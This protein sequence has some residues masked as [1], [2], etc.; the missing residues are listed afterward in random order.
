MFCILDVNHCLL[1]C[2]YAQVND[3]HHFYSQ[4]HSNFPIPGVYQY[5]ELK[6]DSSI[7]F[8]KDLLSS[9]QQLG[10]LAIYCKD[11]LSYKE[12]IARSSTW[13]DMNYN[14]NN[15]DLNQNNVML[16]M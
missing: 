1:W 4:V 15:K 11:L 16:F 2:V 9:L 7:Y 6:N 10:V 13:D 12:N 14:N 5:D 3:G 8:I